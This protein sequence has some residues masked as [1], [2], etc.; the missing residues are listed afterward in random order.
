MNNTQRFQPF[1]LSMN[2][3]SATNMNN[4]KLPQPPNVSGS[5]RINNRF[6]Y[7]P[8]FHTADGLRNRI[9]PPPALGNN[10]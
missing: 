8:N 4:Y 9:P 3:Q 7:Q 5:R 1:N 6:F 10:R 2:G